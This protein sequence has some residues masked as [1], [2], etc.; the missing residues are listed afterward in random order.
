MTR[1][2]IFCNSAVERINKRNGVENYLRR[3]WIN[4]ISFIIA[5]S[6]FKARP[7]QLSKCEDCEHD[8]A[9]VKHHSESIF[10]QI[11]WRRDV[12]DVNS[13]TA[14][15]VKKKE[16]SGCKLPGVRLLSII[17]MME[18]VPTRVNT[19]TRCTNFWTAKNLQGSG[20][21]F[22]VTRRTVKF[23]SCKQYPNL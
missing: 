10:W 3:G 7:W 2:R 6:E 18:K 13:F 9:H 19:Q 12:G 16:P 17:S 1:A 11:Q 15:P 22:H 23:L 21:S 5:S 14:T 8:S 20:F 4:S